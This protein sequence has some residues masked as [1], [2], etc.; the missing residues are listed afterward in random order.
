MRHAFGITGSENDIEYARMGAE[1]IAV[2]VDTITSSSDVPKGMRPYDAARKSVISCVSD[3]AAKG[4]RPRFGV[5]SVTVPP[6]YDV[7]SIKETAR[8]IAD[9]SKKF[10]IRMLG[11]DT[12]FG[13][14]SISVCLFGPS[15]NPVGRGGAKIGDGIFVTGRFGY[16][17]AGLHL[18]MSGKKPAGLFEIRAKKAFCRP[19]ARLDFGAASAERFSSSIDSSDGLAVSL[20]ELAGASGK[21]FLLEKIQIPP[22]LAEFAKK[23]RIAQD[24]LLF[25]GGEEYEIV[26]TAPQ[27][28]WPAIFR[29]AAKHRACLVRIGTV[30]AGSGVS[31]KTGSETA[32]ILRRGWKRRAI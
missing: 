9:A 18:M 7:K 10:K 32:R 28:Q 8:G 30:R 3:F 31:L 29:L 24:N 5:V 17:A 2:A 23:H 12:S 19:D 1:G 25:Y 21:Q 11:G 15:K 6:S 26:F 14:L 27:K 16:S 22:G 20:H 4:T 13:E